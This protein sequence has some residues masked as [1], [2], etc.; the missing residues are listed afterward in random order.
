MRAATAS[1]FPE[2]DIQ[3]NLGVIQLRLNAEKAP[4]SVENFLR[5]VKEG[6][7]RNTIFHRVIR[8]F[9]VQGGGFDKDFKAKTPYAPIVNE[10][11]NGLLNHRGTIAMARTS[12]PN[13]ATSQFFINLENNA[14]L[15]YPGQ[16]GWGYAV[17]G[18]VINGM[19]VVDAIANQ[20]VGAGGPF[21]KDV[22]QSPVII[23]HVFLRP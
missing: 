15:N 7:Y 21:T 1:L 14:A 4:K 5:Y 6:F 13:S 3:T 10:A 20:A 16:D 22:P 18:E 11:Q 17:F 12:S 9:V 19:E 23:E 8:G 2:V